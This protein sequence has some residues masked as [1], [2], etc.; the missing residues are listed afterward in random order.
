MSKV[1]HR[2]S[3]PEP[4]PVDLEALLRG[5]PLLTDNGVRIIAFMRP[6]AANLSLLSP[7]N[8]RTRQPLH[9]DSNPKP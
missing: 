2:S 7:S 6:I 8:Y 5:L 9:Y 1:L 4:L 3:E